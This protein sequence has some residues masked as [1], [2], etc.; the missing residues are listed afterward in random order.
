[1]EFELII[2]KINNTLTEAEAQVFK[3]WYAASKEHRAYFHRV[4]RDYAQNPKEVDIETAWTK[5]ST[6]I[7]PGKP[8]FFFLKYAA[9]FLVL[10]SVTASLYYFQATNIEK[11]GVPK[12]VS[13]TSI[14]TIQP[15]SD[16]AVLTLED[17]SEVVLEKGNDFKSANA[18]SDGEQLVYGSTVKNAAVEIQNN[19][20]NIPRGGQFFVVLADGTKVWMNAETKLKYPVSF[21]DGETRAVELVHG[22]AYFEVS[23]SE[24]HKGARFVVRTG[25][26]D[27]EVF[28]TQFNV[29][30]YADEK[31]VTTTLVEGKVTVTVGET[32][33]KLQPGRQSAYSKETEE[34]QVSKVDVFN[35]ISWKNG[36][37]SFKDMPLE[38]I[39]KVLSRWYDFQ[40]TFDNRDVGKITFNGVFRRV[41]RIEEI[42]NI[43]EATNEVTYK[44]NQNSITMK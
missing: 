4:E 23:P 42:L 14:T 24:L 38:E 9:I 13:K 17:G 10:I 29:K 11:D 7:S 18:S 41:E 6:R 21:I 43:I 12:I 27:V 5:L 15:G 16:K 1:M 22:E 8:R 28:G 3:D 26:H 40:I 33:K 2:K 39:M 31:E 32:S 30:A 19:T 37:F 36:F 44:I 25:N 20:L 35:E 34:V